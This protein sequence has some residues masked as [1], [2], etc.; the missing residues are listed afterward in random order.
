MCQFPILFGKND[1]DPFT[2]ARL[3]A[4]GLCGVGWRLLL[5]AAVATGLQ[6]PF[7]SR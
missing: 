5:G 1:A 3:D 2:A 6:M 4:F 7:L